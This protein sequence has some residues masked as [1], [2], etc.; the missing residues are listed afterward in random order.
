M[1]SSAPTA[2]A[3]GSLARW[4]RLPHMAEIL[5]AAFVLFTLLLISPL[6]DPVQWELRFLRVWFKLPE[7][8]RQE[9]PLDWQEWAAAWL[10]R[11]IARMSTAIT[12]TFLPAMEQMAASMDQAT[13]A[14]LE[15]G[16]SLQ[17]PIRL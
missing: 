3:S 10:S 15:L 14:I 9:A 5:I 17:P 13:A 11:E 8:V 1:S 12:E 7:W 2:D 6:C 4:S 16:A